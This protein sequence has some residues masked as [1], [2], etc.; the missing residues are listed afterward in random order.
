MPKD[1]VKEQKVRVRKNPPLLLALVP[2]VCLIAI[3]LPSVIILKADPQIPLIIC[4]AITSIIAICFLGRNWQEIE[5]SMIDTNMMAMQA[6]FIIMIVGCL[7]AT[8]IAG[9]IV[10][11]MI[12]Y[13]LKLFSPSIFLAVLPIICAIIAV[14]TGSA[15]TTAG[16]MGAAAMGIAAGLGIP[17]AIAAG[18]V[19]TG[20]S[21]GDKLSP[22]SDST[23]LAAGVA[24][25]N[26]FEHVRHMLYTTVPSFLIAVGIFA[27]IGSRYGAESVDTT[28]IDMILATIEAN[29]NITPLVFIAPL[30][31]ILMIV[32]KVPAIPGMLGGT[33]I[34]VIFAATQGNGLGDILSQM[35]YGMD[36]NTGNVLVDTLLNRGGMQ[37]MMFTISLVICALAFGG[38]VK[39]AGCLDTI[40]AAI[41]SKCH[42][43]GSIMTANVFTCIAMN[44]M[45][46][47]QYMAIV[48]PGQMYKKVYEKLNLAPKNLS[49]V[50]EDAGT[51]TSGLVP[52][53]TCG[54]IYLATLGVSAFQY[55][56][57]CFLGMI[58][59][60][61]SILYAFTGFT[62]EPLDKS[63]PIKKSI[64]IEE[65]NQ[66]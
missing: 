24:G 18:A 57:Y 1:S 19:V 65:M 21:F 4:T 25:T 28:Q 37:S 7:V 54:A 10:P 55:A 53:S 39:A 62:L 61:V 38:A 45:A 35:I 16:T 2:F 9:G 14:S 29:F 50:L 6:N 56:P 31:V 40:I 23:N 59:P 66:P 52:W 36:L 33:I 49:R 15:W 22:L 34:G 13:G 60:L 47:D 30:S 51:L 3:M 58:C 42:S 17:P 26:L 27:I 48:I 64:T 41:L 43:R 32:F 11:G 8:W 12:Y 20:A 46:A 5:D 63:K 44:F